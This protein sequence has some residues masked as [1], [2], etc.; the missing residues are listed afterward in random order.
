MCIC[1][2]PYSIVELAINGRGHS[3][4]NIWWSRFKLQECLLKLNGTFWLSS[5]WLPSSE[6]QRLLG[7]VFPSITLQDSD[8]FHSV[9]ST[10]IAHQH[11]SSR[12][13]YFM[14]VHIHI[15]T[16]S[17]RPF[18]SRRVALR[19]VRFT[20]LVSGFVTNRGASLNFIFDSRSIETLFSLQPYPSL[21]QKEYFHSR[22]RIS[23][24]HIN[25]QSL[26]QK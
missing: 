18:V 3:N 13:I 22:G 5:R 15:L 1:S 2:M 8:H 23:S 10:C 9:I 6:I 24:L 20:R 21:D 14:S 16:A 19:D 4:T 17:N 12:G 25:C 7:A 26:N 11:A